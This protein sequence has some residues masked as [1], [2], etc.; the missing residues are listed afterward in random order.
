MPT[1]Q[2]L[3]ETGTD[4]L[5]WGVILGNMDLTD[6]DVSLFC[7]WRHDASLPD[8]DN[9]DSRTARTELSALIPGASDSTMRFSSINCICP[10]NLG[11]TTPNSNLGNRWVAPKLHNSSILSGKELPPSWN[12]AFIVTHYVSVHLWA[13]KGTGSR[14]AGWHR[15][16]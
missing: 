6:A 10:A 11:L 1:D 8:R 14:G 2:K 15:S 13:E 4:R 7:R 3:E 16:R 9:I 12:N 5:R